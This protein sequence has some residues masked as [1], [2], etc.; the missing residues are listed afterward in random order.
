MI[1][2]TYS[3]FRTASDMAAIPLLLELSAPPG[4]KL[5]S[6]I[7]GAQRPLCGQS[8]QSLPPHLAPLVVLDTL[9]LCS[10]VWSLDI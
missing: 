1:A 5:R 8:P 2:R 7:I 3:S 6:A 10:R 9:L 4:E